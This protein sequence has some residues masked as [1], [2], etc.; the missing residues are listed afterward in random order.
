MK[1]YGKEVA[2]LGATYNTTKFELL[3]YML[4]V[5][6]NAGFVVVGTFIIGRDTK[7]QIAAA[8]RIIRS[9]VPCWCPQY[10]L[11]DYDLREIGALGEVFEG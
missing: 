8:L 10:F 2:V 3:L 9:W 6:T 1:K 7:A 5:R 11:T 4:A